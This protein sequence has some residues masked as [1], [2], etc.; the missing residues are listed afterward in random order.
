MKEK[1]VLAM[2]EVT[3]IG[4][5]KIL[6]GFSVYCVHILRLE[7]SFEWLPTEA[8]RR[9]QQYSR[10]R[11]RLKI[12]PK[13][14]F[15]KPFKPFILKLCIYP[16]LELNVN[17]IILSNIHFKNICVAGG[18]SRTTCLSFMFQYV[19]VSLEIFGFYLLELKD[20]FRLL[21][22]HY[23]VLWYTD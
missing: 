14:V 16:T 17:M 13:L 21:S 22:G 3:S 15:G 2:G 23:R 8:P 7:R 18:V 5:N 6:F 1:T 4:L 20:M 10:S 9:Q 12:F 19:F 11:I